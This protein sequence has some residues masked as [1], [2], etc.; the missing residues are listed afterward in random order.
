[1]GMTKVTGRPE[2]DP[3]FLTR[4]GVDIPD[5]AY[6]AGCDVV[7]VETGTAAGLRY[8]NAIDAAAP[9][10]VAAELERQAA[11]F[12]LEAEGTDGGYHDG[13]YG[14][15][16]ALQRRAAQLRGEA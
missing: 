13:M 4:S 14:A 15:A 5:E 1:M 12:R 2:E 7:A 3:V 11:W 16:I 9:L 10:I 6:V 8:Q